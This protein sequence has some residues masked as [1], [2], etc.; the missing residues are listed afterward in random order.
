[1]LLTF[2]QALKVVIL[3]VWSLFVR[4]LVARLAEV[5]VL[6][7]AWWLPQFSGRGGTVGALACMLLN[8]IRSL[9]ILTVFALFWL[10]LWLGPMTSA[11]AGL[12]RAHY[13]GL[14]PIFVDTECACL[15]A[16]RRAGYQRPVAGFDG[17]GPGR[18]RS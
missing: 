7:L 4:S 15:A 12:D 14:C 18:D 13:L 10:P 17:C 9:A 3:V 2:V 11:L 16:Y 6:G 1:M 5:P 8:P